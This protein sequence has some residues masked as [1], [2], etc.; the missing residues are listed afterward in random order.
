MW[1]I[2]KHKFEKYV[3]IDYQI[4]IIV[5][6][7]HCCKMIWWR[8]SIF[9]VFKLVGKKITRLMSL[10]LLVLPHW[11]LLVNGS[12]NFHCGRSVKRLLIVYLPTG[13]LYRLLLCVK[14]SLV[15]KMKLGLTDHNLDRPNNI[16]SYRKHK[17]LQDKLEEWIPLLNLNTISTM[18]N[19]R[20][21]HLN[22]KLDRFY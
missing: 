10:K 16:L 4:I 8:L 12:R 17:K 6:C 1:K 3:Q 22:F 2:Q 9:I 18:P 7:N 20:H 19:I 13:Y 15:L 14:W 5:N 11:N 21:H